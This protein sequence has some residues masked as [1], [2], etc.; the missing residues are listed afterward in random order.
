MGDTRYLDAP[1]T[2]NAKRDRLRFWPH[3]FLMAIVF[4]LFCAPV[5]LGSVTVST[6]FLK[7]ASISNAQ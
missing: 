3:A 6:P 5:V 2:S 7:L 4:S 1:N